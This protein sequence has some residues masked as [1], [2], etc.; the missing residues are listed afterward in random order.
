MKHNWKEAATLILTA[1]KG[2]SVKSGYD[3]TIL[4]LKRSTKTSFMPKGY[5]YPGGTVEVAD[6]SMK[7]SSFFPDFI[8][9]SH[10]TSKL[11]T[12]PP[13]LE[14]VHNLPKLL[15]LKVAAIRET[16][17]ETGILLCCNMSQVQEG[18]NEWITCSM[19]PGLQEWRNKV[20][21]D[22]SEFYNLCQHYK[23]CP[24][25]QNIY[26]WS[27][28]LTPT[29]TGN[30]RYDTI[31]FIACLKE[32]PYAVAD[33][34][35]IEYLSWISPDKVM[36]QHKNREIFVPPPQ[37]YET[38]RLL[39]FDEIHC[40]SN[41]AKQRSGHGCERW[42]PVQFK[43]TDGMVSLLPGDD[44]YHPV[45][46][47][48]LSEPTEIDMSVEEFRTKSFVCHRLESMGKSATNVA[49]HN[50]RAT[51]GHVLPIRDYKK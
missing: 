2:V 33:K 9:K 30:K 45:N 4:N 14:G 38:L 15:T 46:F 7:W 16:F 21:K 3:Y 28:W 42:M 26:L 49:L 6:S 40:L 27:N 29:S 37:V 24:D 8:K 23:C 10:D 32:M 51:N 34:G 19:Y 50:Y 13:I 35:E 22:A 12:V 36:D 1:F 25:V 11:R 18:N 48:T 20:Q 17:E 41:F 31:F 39:Q 43:A 5:V 47:C 44:G